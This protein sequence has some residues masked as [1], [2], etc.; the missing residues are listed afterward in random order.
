MWC[1]PEY[2]LRSQCIRWCPGWCR[3]WWRCPCPDTGPWWSFWDSASYSR[4][5]APDEDWVWHLLNWTFFTW[6]IFLW[7]QTWYQRKRKTYNSNSLKGENCSSK[8][9]RI[10]NASSSQREVDGVRNILTRENNVWKS[11]P[12]WTFKKGAM[13]WGVQKV[14]DNEYLTCISLS[15]YSNNCKILLLFKRVAFLFEL[16]LTVINFYDA[17][18]NFQHHHFSLQCHM[19]KKHLLLPTLKAI[20]LLHIFVQTMIPWL[21]D[22]LNTLLLRV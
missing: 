21:T 17:K 12:R 8:E 7:W 2:A 6:I 3:G 5:V 4:V 13:Y 22:E 9:E 10:V 11:V 14:W 1:C 20:V 16:F 15:K 18:L 19:L